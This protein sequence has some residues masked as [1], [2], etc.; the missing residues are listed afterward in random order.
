[1]SLALPLLLGLGLSALLGGS[2]RKLAD[3]RLRSVWMFY[4]AI[5]LQVAAFPVEAMPWRTPDTV[6]KALWLG[7]DALIA[8]AAVRN[9]RIPGVAF[10]GAGLVS[11][12]AAVLSNGGHM[13]VRA[14]AMHAAGYDYAVHNNSAALAS[15]HLSWLIDR[16]A[17]PDWI[18]F[19]NVFSVGDVLIA[20]GGFMFAVAATGAVASVRAR[21]ARP[22]TIPA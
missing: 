4:A 11:N 6:A 7:S 1:M 8:V 18:P 15:P 14:A 12:L 17:A 10:V 13:P 22:G 21:V 9:L 19:A 20:A 16:W 5:G 2:L 3:L